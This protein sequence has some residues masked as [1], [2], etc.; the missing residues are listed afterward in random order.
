MNK[1]LERPLSW[2]QNRFDTMREQEVKCYLLFRQ[3]E[4]GEYNCFFPYTKQGYKVALDLAKR[5]GRGQDEIL[6]TTV[7]LKAV[8][9]YE[10]R[11]VENYWKWCKKWG[12][13]EI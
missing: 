8:L 1:A 5:L 2:H 9:P 11:S 4:D 10:V 3:T 12:F 7:Q 6:I 13:S